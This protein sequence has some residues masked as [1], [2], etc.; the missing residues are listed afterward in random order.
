MDDEDNLGALSLVAGNAR[1]SDAIVVGVVAEPIDCEGKI[2]E[3]EIMKLH[4]NTD[5]N[6]VIQKDHLKNL[7]RMKAGAPDAANLPEQVLLRAVTSISDVITTPGYQNV[8]LADI[9][10][11]MSNSGR[12]M[13]G[14]GSASGKHR[15]RHAAH[16]AITS[17]QFA[18]DI[19][20]DARGVLINITGNENMSITECNEACT[21]IKAAVSRDADIISGYIVNP[22]MK[23]ELLVTVVA[24]GIHDRV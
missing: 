14:M 15:A 6:I 21:I 5:A 11:I 9:K 1:K 19:I 20:K 7:S 22:G 17:N 4:E 2:G 10:R 8:D 12:S 24:T 23:E 3:E 13:V 18:N 16:M